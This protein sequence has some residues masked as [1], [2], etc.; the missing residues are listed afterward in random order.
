SISFDP[1]DDGVVYAT[2]AG[3]G[4][5]A[6]VWKSPDGGTTWSPL[7]GSGS[8]QLPDIPAHSLAVDPTHAGRLYL[9]S[10]LGIFVSNDAGEH[11]QVENTGFAPVITELVLIAA[12]EHGPAVYAFTHG[13]GV[14]RAEL[15]EP[16][17]RRAVR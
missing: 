1:A 3:F 15:V 17:R 14:W 10:D 11:W 9:G 8:D 16:R 13:R 5:G 4:G 2:Y 12:G 6:H 7:D